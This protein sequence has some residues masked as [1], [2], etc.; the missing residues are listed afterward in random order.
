VLVIMKRAATNGAFWTVMTK[1]GVLL[2]ELHK[3]IVTG[4][5]R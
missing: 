3:F 5:A 1:R 4:A 2:D